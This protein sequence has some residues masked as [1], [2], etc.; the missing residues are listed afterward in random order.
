MKMLTSSVV[1]P[2]EQGPLLT[3]HCSTVS[4][5]DRPVT[6]V[7]GELGDVMFAVPLITTHSPPPGKMVALP[8]RVTVTP[9]PLSQID[10]SG[11]AFATPCCA[12]NTRIV[13]GSL[14]M[15][16]APLSMFQTRIVAPTERP[17]TV[18]LNTVG[19]A[20]VAVPCWTVQKPVARPV[21]ALPAKVVP[22]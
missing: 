17:V 15:P 7:T 22:P 1:K 19:S 8:S 4:P 11:P 13:I 18:V 3:C 5:G 6:V 12:S 16:H 21:G 2:G 9:P 14:L 20:N 10:W